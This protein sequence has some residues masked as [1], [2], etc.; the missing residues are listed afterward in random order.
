MVFIAAVGIYAELVREI[1][2]YDPPLLLACA[3]V[4]WPVPAWTCRQVLLRRS[5]SS[6]EVADL[7]H[8]GAAVYPAFTENSAL[9]DEMLSLFIAHGVDI[10]A[11]DDKGT[12][13]W[14]ALQTMAVAG[15]PDR[16]EMLLKHGA[17]TDLRDVANMT[18]LDLARQMQEKHPNEPNRVEVIRLLEEAE[19][20]LTAS[21]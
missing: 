18:A 5:F 9:A 10:N 3:D 6:A 21:K 15:K 1:R 20:H 17:R 14:T 16:V 4:E 8:V 13:H 11:P 2:Q 19:K 7:N 12:R